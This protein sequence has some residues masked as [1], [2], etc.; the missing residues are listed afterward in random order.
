MTGRI[1]IVDDVVTNIKLLEAKLHREYYEII[2]ATSGAGAIEKARSHSP[3]LILLDVMMPGLDGFEVC[4]QLKSDPNCFNIPIVM[5]T[6]LTGQE[7]RLRGL[8][9]GAD[10]FL[11]KPVNDVPL[12][13]RVRSLI[14]LKS[15]IDMW[16]VREESVQKLGL[17]NFSLAMDQET[18]INGNIIFV[19]NAKLLIEELA[20]T[21]AQDHDNCVFAHS[22]SECQALLQTKNFELVVIGLDIGDNDALRLTSQ[23]RNSSIQAIRTLPIL[24]LSMNDNETDIIANALD[25]GI[26]DYVMSPVHK[27][28]F[29]AR[30][31]TQIRRYRFQERLRTNYEHSISLATIDP[32]T[33]VYNRRFLDTNLSQILSRSQTSH[34]PLSVAFCDLDRFK[35][36]NDTYG[37]QAGDAV[38]VEFARRLQNNLRS[39]DLVAR[40]GGE[41]FIV[42]MPDTLIETGAMV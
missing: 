5:I 30:V 26:S 20:E 11:S 17:R 9:A 31:R 34:K 40:M 28:E 41:E 15:L 8:A 29:M 37:H 18:F 22:A 7:D 10:D 38:L 27:S 3:D 24:I 21:L 35:S 13:A 4:R 16:R 6:A 33:N 1:L 12:L 2:S 39:N 23:I 42:I 36:L 32:L 25:I 14:R 19:S